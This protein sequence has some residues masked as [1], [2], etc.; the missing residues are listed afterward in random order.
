MIIA[1][2]LLTFLD[3]LSVV[4]FDIFDLTGIACGVKINQANKLV[5]SFLLPLILLGCASLSS[6]IAK[7]KLKSRIHEAVQNK[8]IQGMWLKALGAAFDL[9]DTD[10]SHELDIHELETLLH[11]V[12]G[13]RGHNHD[14]EYHQEANRLL[15]K[16][17]KNGSGTLSKEYFLRKM[18][19]DQNYSGNGKDQQEQH[20]KLVT[21]VTGSSI[22]ANRFG[23][24]FNLLFIAHSPISQSAFRW[25]DCRSIGDPTIGGNSFLH[26]DYSIHC[27]NAFH[28]SY[29]PLVILMIC[30]Y[31][32]GIPLFFG[33]YLFNHR[34]EFV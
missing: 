16:W 7:Q 19:H 17:D 6:F 3:Y 9:I 27:Y 2:N 31:S 26:A 24:A 13:H 12:H 20:V 10:A 23:T 33:I 32:I 18:S 30:V 8:Q 34:S 11:V 14:S 4:Q 1:E 5:F 22:D 25:L 28:T 15:K 29:V 21:F